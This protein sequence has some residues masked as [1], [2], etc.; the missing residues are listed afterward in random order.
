MNIPNAMSV[1]R[2]LLIPVFLIAYLVYDSL[3]WSIAILALSAL[4]DVL[5]GIIARKFNMITD[6]GKLLDPLADKM[7]Q[8]AIALA[9]ASKFPDLIPLLA[10]FALKEVLMVSG[11][12]RLLKK[13]QRPCEAQWYGKLATV[14][15]YAV[16]VVIIAFD[17]F[18][19]T[20][21]TG[22]QI[23]LVSFAALFMIHAFVRYSMF[24]KRIQKDGKTGET[25]VKNGRTVQ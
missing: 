15:F 8:V 14:V 10:V 4:S 21:S 13:G 20:L 6:L 25:Q 19:K 17:V 3:L 23:V 12:I 7:T 11:S 24:F 22:V 9:L 2:I 16:M 1:F 5:D 18:N